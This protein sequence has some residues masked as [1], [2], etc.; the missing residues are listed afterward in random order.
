MQKFL[1]AK[2][3][4]SLCVPRQ[5]K[6]SALTGSAFGRYC[7]GTRYFTRT[8]GVGSAEPACI[9]AHWRHTKL[10]FLKAKDRGN[11]YAF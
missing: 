1:A 10:R 11:E 8:V 6:I 7:P 3:L 2:C 4:Q 5:R 9:S